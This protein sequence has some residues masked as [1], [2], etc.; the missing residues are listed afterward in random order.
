[1]GQRAWFNEHGTLIV[2]ETTDSEI[3]A[4]LHDVESEE[5]YGSQYSGAQQPPENDSDSDSPVGN[6]PEA[7][8][9]VI[10]PE[11]QWPSDESED[12]DSLFV[13][14]PWANCKEEEEFRARL[15]KAADIGHD[16]D[17]EWKRDYTDEEIATKYIQRA[18]D[19]G[20]VW[21]GTEIIRAYN[22]D[23]PEGEEEVRRFIDSWFTDEML[24]A[25]G[26]NVPQPWVK[27]EPK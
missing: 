21:P 6:I 25:W 14:Q 3:D 24:M 2:D 11:M 26:G 19:L 12:D 5:Y 16:V 8:V 27:W 9:S 4:W 22:D 1:M 13:V 20:V 7:D 10:W 17:A 23:Q 15:R 18:T